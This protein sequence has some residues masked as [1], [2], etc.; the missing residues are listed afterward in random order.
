[1]PSSRERL[2]SI[3]AL[4]SILI[5]VGVLARPAPVAALVP[6][7]NGPLAFMRKVGTNWDVYVLR[8]DGSEARLTTQPG[9]DTLPVWSPDGSRLAFSSSPVKDKEGALDIWV[10]NADGSGPVQLTDH[11]ADDRRHVESAST[12][13][14]YSAAASS[15]W[16]AI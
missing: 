1:M 5:L 11:P 12:E 7:P 9:A 3:G 14:A 8:I 6:G 15:H 13:R 10:M 4:L 2:P 16:A